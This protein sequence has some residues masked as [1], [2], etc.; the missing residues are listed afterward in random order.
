MNPDDRPPVQG[1][2]FVRDGTLV[3]VCPRCWRDLVST[4]LLVLRSYGHAQEWICLWCASWEDRNL[5]ER[6]EPQAEDGEAC[7]WCGA[8]PPCPR[9]RHALPDLE[10]RADFDTVDPGSISPDEP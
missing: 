6:P 1:R 10:A 7:Y 2:R 8:V 3:P 5:P 4:D 9:W